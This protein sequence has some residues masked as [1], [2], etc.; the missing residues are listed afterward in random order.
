MYRE[1]NRQITFAGKT[2]VTSRVAQQITFQ[3]DV[4]YIPAAQQL[5]SWVIRFTS[6]HGRLA[7]TAALEQILRHR[8]ESERGVCRKSP[9]C[10]FALC[11]GKSRVCRRF[12]C[13]SILP[14]NPA[15]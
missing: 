9:E 5:H 14:L 15:T 11:S 13:T 6:L 3:E 1:C 7:A 10:V 12:P 8:F 4:D 2:W